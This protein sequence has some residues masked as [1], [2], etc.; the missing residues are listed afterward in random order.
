MNKKFASVALETNIDK[1]LD[2]E[3]PSDLIDTLKE[4]MLVE[5][6]LRNSIKQGYVLKI[7][8]EAEVKKTSMIS[9]ITKESVLTEDLFKL[10]LWM[11]DYYLISLS[12]AIRCMIPTGVIKQISLK[13]NC[14]IYSIK[15]KNELVKIISDL[16]KKNPQQAEVL[17]IILKEKKGIFLKDLIKK[18]DI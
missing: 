7:K 1:P 8:D 18:I 2:Y 3:I 4:G 10:A 15:T 16:L 13:L 11:K 17:S 5:V 6:P 12:K 9:K 14:F